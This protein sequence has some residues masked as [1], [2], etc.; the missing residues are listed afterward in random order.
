MGKTQVMN[1]TARHYFF[2]I[3]KA[4]IIAV[5]ISL[6][7]ILG[8]AFL[9]KAVNIPASMI[10]IIN[11]VIKGVSILTACLICLR[12]PHNGWLRGIMVGIVYIFAAYLIFSLLDGAKFS[13]GLGLLN[14]LALGSVSGLLSGVVSGLI[15]RRGPA[16]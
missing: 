13:F 11:Q 9:I 1:P 15:R 6:A 3:V 10:P 16:R 7:A 2:E 4:I 5:I 14:D 8:L 12:L